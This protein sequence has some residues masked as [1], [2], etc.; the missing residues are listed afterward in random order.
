MLYPNSFQCHWEMGVL[1]DTLHEA[2]VL[3]HT[4]QHIPCAFEA[5]ASVT[6]IAVAGD[7]VRIVDL[8]REEGLRAGLRIGVAPVAA[9]YM[10]VRIPAYFEQTTSGA[11]LYHCQPAYDATVRPTYW[12]QL[13]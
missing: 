9:P 11:Y 13:F 7:T 4:P 6:I 3:A 10:R 1:G 5:S 2:I 8:C 12:G